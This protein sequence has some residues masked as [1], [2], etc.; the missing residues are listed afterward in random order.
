MINHEPDSSTAIAPPD[1][2]A[3]SGA[4]RHPQVVTAK[5]AARIADAVAR[6]STKAPTPARWNVEGAVSFIHRHPTISAG[7]AA[8][9]GVLI[10]YY[11]P[12]RRRTTATERYVKEPLQRSRGLLVSFLFGVVTFLRRIIA[13]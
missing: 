6:H 8:L 10:G 7:G 4:A 1:A 12:R 5:A 3:H 9:A 11:F 13:R 2:P